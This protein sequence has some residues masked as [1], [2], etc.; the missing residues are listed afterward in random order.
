MEIREDL[1]NNKMIQIQNGWILIFIFSSFY[2]ITI[3]FSI[4]LRAC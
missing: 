4:I 2:V 3:L 1:Q